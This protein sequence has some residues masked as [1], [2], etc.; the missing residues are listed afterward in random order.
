M[1]VKV[2]KGGG[3]HVSHTLIN[4]GVKI[5][6]MVERRRASS[7][8]SGQW[9]NAEQ[10]KLVE[11]LRYTPMEM[12]SPLVAVLVPVLGRPAR[13]EPL[14]RSF[15]ETSSAHARLYFIAQQSDLDEVA[16]I[17]ATGYEPIIV[18]DDDRSWARKINRGYNKT[19]ETWMLLGADDIAFAPGWIDAIMPILQEHRGVI[20]TNDLGNHGTIHGTHSTHPLVHRSYADLCGTVDERNSVVHGNYDHNYPDTELVAT[21]V[22]RGLYVHRADCVIEHLHP[23]WG[24][25]Q[26]DATYQ[27][28]NLKVQQDAALFTS[29]RSLF[30]F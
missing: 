23:A 30:G 5:V 3:R 7:A 9:P 19:S 1:G 10:I 28:G 25:G 6:N 27:R 13:V 14:V 22:R 17:R 29:R 26:D 2:I 15:T 24:K 11:L 21:A 16:A 4:R 18:G 12:T 8:L 20:G